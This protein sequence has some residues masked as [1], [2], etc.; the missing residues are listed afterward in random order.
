[1]KTEHKIKVTLTTAE[2]ASIIRIKYA[3][4]ADSI[5]DV[6]IDDSTELTEIKGRWYFRDDWFLLMK[7]GDIVCAQPIIPLIQELK[8]Y[9]MTVVPMMGRFQIG[10][11]LGVKIHPHEL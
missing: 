11:M 7:L 4:P 6:V 3:F 10:I 1:M 2:L 9:S 5:I 8:Q